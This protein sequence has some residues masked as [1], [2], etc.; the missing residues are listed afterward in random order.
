[1]TD[2]F[3]HQKRIFFDRWA[4]FYDFLLTTV[5]YQAIHRRLLSYVTLPPQ[6]QVLDLG[7]GTGR[8]LNRLGEQ[9]PDF[10]GIGLDLSAEMIKQ[11]RRSNTHHPQLIFLRG[12]ATALPFGNG[13]FDAVFNTISFL[14]Y[15]NPQRVLT[16]IRRVLQPEGYFYLVDY[17]VAQSGQFSISPGGLRLYSPQKREEMGQ[18]VGLSC[19]GH[20]YLFG[21]VLLTLFKAI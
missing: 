14:H 18:G 4:N 16:E 13:Q 7:C 15:P 1:M 10:L 8:L 11:A 3:L 12:E 2:S 6:A 19:Q 5:I 17:T 21:R 9:Y 20:H